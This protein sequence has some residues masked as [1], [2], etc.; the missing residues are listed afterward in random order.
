MPGRDSPI[1]LAASLGRVAY[2]PREFSITLAM[3][4]T[5]VEYDARVSEI[6]NRYAG[7]LVKVVRSEL[8]EV[9]AVGTLQIEA[10]YDP[11]ARKGQ[12]VLSCEDGDA[13]LYY[14][15]E[16][17]VVHSGS[18]TV[19]LANDY[20]PVVPKV[21]TTAETTLRWSIG[22]DEFSKTV[23]TGTWEI[24]ELELQAGD[25]SVSIS[26]SGTTTFRYREGRL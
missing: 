19:M 21:E 20:M 23:S 5:R 18:G 10:E 24:P 3:L 1:R 4:G 25:N 2:Q 13:W 11:M 26:S 22:G 12:L 16:T 6:A 14:V 8:P 9:Y 15:S 17:V 7:R